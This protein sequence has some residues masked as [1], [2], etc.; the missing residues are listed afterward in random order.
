MASAEEGAEWLIAVG[1]ASS[2][3][4]VPCL[5]SSGGK[6]RCYSTLPACREIVSLFCTEH[7]LESCDNAGAKLSVDRGTQLKKVRASAGHLIMVMFGV[8]T[9]RDAMMVEVETE[10]WCKGPML[11]E[12]KLFVALLC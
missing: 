10:I 2:G 4:S 5:T 9:N 11:S 7:A 8:H 6:K 1:Q 3:D 12:A